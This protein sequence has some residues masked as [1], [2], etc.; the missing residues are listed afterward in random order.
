[1]ILDSSPS[2]VLPLTCLYTC[3]Y[4]CKE[5]HSFPSNPMSKSQINTYDNTCKLNTEFCFWKCKLLH[6]NMEEFV[7]CDKEPKKKK[8]HVHKWDAKSNLS[9]EFYMNLPSFSI[10]LPVRGRETGM[11]TLYLSSKLR[12]LQKTNT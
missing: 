12:K 1:M 6:S 3:D 5:I 11:D 9:E 4:S 7:K 8:E 2:W 10:Y